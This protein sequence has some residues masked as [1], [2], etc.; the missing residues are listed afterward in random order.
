VMV[1]LGGLGS[2]PGVVLGAA[3][4][5]LLNIDILQTLSLL[6]SSLRQGNDVIPLIGVPWKNLPTQLDPARYQRFVF[7]LLLII[8]MIFRPEGMVPAERA[9]LE[10]HEG[11][12]EFAPEV[13]LESEAMPDKQLVD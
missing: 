11:E 6:L 13:R 9:R 8:M 2:I 4:V 12:E 7:G 10:L 3:V 5:T 1:I